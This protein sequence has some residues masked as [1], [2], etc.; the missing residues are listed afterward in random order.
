MKLI[1]PIKFIL[2]LFRKPETKLQKLSEV[3]KY[4]IAQREDVVMNK[5]KDFFKEDVFNTLYPYAKPGTYDAL[6]KNF[7]DYDLTTKY[8]VAMFISQC[9]HESGG[10]RVTSENLNYSAA[11]LNAVFPKYFKNAGRDA[12]E[13]ERH[14]EKIANVVYAN[15]MG[16]NSEGDGWKFRGRGFIQLTGKNN[17]QA[18]NSTLNPPTD[19][20]NN[21]ELVSQ[22]INLC[23]KSALWYWDSNNLN[24]YADNQDVR[25][26]TI[27]ING[28]L[29][30]FA[31]RN[32]Q[33]EK[34]IK[35][36]S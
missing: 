5:I 35:T 13:Y 19:I 18:F 7:P 14:P 15:R 26:C 22:D 24:K 33:Y 8:R 10:F 34:L 31:D 4:F 16:N 25:G 3:D 12:Y 32:K 28:G 9:G 2:G 11:A 23:V 29:N 6:V 21:P 30:G 27:A 20:L 36:F 17:Y 1:K